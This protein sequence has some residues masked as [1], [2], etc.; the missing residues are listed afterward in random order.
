MEF[1]E[2]LLFFGASSSLPSRFRLSLSRSNL[3]SHHTV[4]LLTAIKVSP[5]SSVGEV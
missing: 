2:R 3:F 4:A 1:A 5:N